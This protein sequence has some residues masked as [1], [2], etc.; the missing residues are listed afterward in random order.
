[1]KANK[2]LSSQLPQLLRKQWERQK[3]EDQ[4]AESQAHIERLLLIQRPSVYIF[5]NMPFDVEVFLN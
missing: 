5:L 4:L 1:M 3:R 2:G